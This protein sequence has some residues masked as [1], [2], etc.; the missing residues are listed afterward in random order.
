MTTSTLEVNGK[1]ISEVKVVVNGAGAA[2][3]S[4][5]RLYIALGVD[6][7][8]VVMLDSKGVIST[9]RSG[10]T[11]EKVEFATERTDIQTLAE[12]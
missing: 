4:C 12:L 8:N 2:A 7:K 11:P 10:L 5:A 9:Q 3:I 1:K 6:P